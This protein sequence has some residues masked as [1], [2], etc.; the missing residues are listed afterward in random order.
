M[1]SNRVA[2]VTGAGSGIGRGAAVAL[3]NAGYSVALAGRRGAELEKTAAA[4]K[5]G[6][7]RSLVVP[8]DATKPA[9]VDGLFARTQSTFGHLDVLFNNVGKNARTAFEDVTFEEWTSLVDANL[10]SAFLCA[11]AA[12]RI[13]KSQTP[14]GG[15]IINNG[16]T[17]I[18]APRPNGAPYG[19]TKSGITGL[20]KSIAIDGRKYNIACS[21]IDLGNVA[22]EMSHQLTIGVLQANGTTMPEPRMDI[23]HVVDA[24][25]W[26]ANL[27]LD[28]NVQFIT[29]M[30]TNM[31]LYGRG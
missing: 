6:A 24:V 16:S 18:H 27:P 3:L 31:P 25:L 13:M 17:A 12:Y 11:Q 28:V 20:T 8:M 26:M 29:L 4:A 5:A 9:E 7:G 19:A 22:T 15:R 30:P 1:N 10:T 23:Q 2:V 21:Q 14:Q